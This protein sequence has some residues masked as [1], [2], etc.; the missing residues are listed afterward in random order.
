[1]VRIVKVKISVYTYLREKL[2][3]REKVV[4]IPGKDQATLEE[5]LKQVPELYELVVVDG[6]I[7]E[8]YI[9]F[10]DGIHAQFVGGLNAVVKDGSEIAVFPPGGGG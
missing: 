5:V 9:V 10:V 6:R 7:A 1:V 2:G 3:W 8:G 4:E